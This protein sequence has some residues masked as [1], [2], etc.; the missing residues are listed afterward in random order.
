MKAMNIKILAGIFLLTVFLFINQPLEGQIV[1]GQPPSGELKFIYQ[2]WS[3][4]DTLGVTMD[5]NQWVLPIYGFVPIK[6]NFEFIFTSSTAGTNQTFD[7]GGSETSLSGLNDTRM[8]VYGSFMEDR[9]LVGL[10]MNL[11]TGKK[12]LTNDEIGIA[13]LLTESFFNFPVKNY[14]EGF[15]INLEA[16]YA[17]N[18]DV[19]TY[20]VGMGYTL[21]TSYEPLQGADNYKPGNM[22]RIGGYGSIELEK[23]LGRL[24][25]VYNV[26]GEDKLD[27]TP[28]FKDGNIFDTRLEFNY[29]EDKFST[30]AGIR[31]IVRG[32]DKRLNEGVLETEPDKS[33]GTEM[34]LYGRATYL[35]NLRVGVTALLDYKSVG[36]NGYP[37]D[38]IRAFGSSN[39]FGIGFGGNAL[40]TEMFRG[41]AE[42]EYFTGSADGGNLD[43]S[44]W[45]IG[46][47]LG[48]AF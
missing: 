8:S 47:G 21:K 48:A 27:G 19:Y 9:I 40:I 46:L 23:V 11:P 10:G 34:R 37:E 30:L 38:N 3:I 36:A 45:Q 22:F 25:I 26:Y 32:K 16:G 39:Y 13:D 42:F 24:S 15:G 28:V 1:F 18:Y 12:A 41:F 20:G 5:L 4:D 6:E 35:V 17:Q 33:H 43:L 44:G 29:S 14:G 7:E 2:S 31:G